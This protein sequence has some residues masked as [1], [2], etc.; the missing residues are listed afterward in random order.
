M[1]SVC[2]EIDLAQGGSRW[3]NKKGS[4]EGS[5]EFKATEI[6]RFSAQRSDPSSDLEIS[7]HTT[8]VVDSLVG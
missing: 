3:K 6:L 2:G 5:P 1:F 7:L 8:C 4:V